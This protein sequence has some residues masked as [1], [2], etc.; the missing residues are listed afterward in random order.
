MN[1]LVV[2]D[3]FSTLAQYLFRLGNSVVFEKLTVCYFLSV[4]SATE[5]AASLPLF[6]FGRVVAMSCEIKI[7]EELCRFE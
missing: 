5:E 6:V 7:C 1:I 3:R 4:W 2:K